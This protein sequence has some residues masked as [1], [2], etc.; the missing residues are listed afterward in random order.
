MNFLRLKSE[1]VARFRQRYP[2]YW[3]D[4][5]VEQVAASRRREADGRGYGEIRL[6]GTVLA[7]L[8]HAHLD[9]QLVVP[10]LNIVTDAGDIYY[11]QS[12]AAET[13]DNDFDHANSGLRLGDDN[14]T[15]TK[16]DTDVTSFLSGSAHALD[17]TYE[18]TDDDDT[19]NSGAGANVVTWRYSYTTGE[20]NVADIIEGAIVD[21]RT[22]PTA[23]LTH[24]L[25]A[26]V[27]TKTSSD[28]LTVYVNH[29]MLGA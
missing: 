13:P 6:M 9:L 16:A 24:F 14:T 3:L 25:F 28:T 11:A 12:A 4:R 23:A 10:G 15:P 22:T 29:E 17:A 20:G 18:K 8:R 5:L 1:A 2:Q 27:F 26:G 21:N 19:N 7:V